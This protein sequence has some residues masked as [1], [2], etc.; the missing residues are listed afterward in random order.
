MATDWFCLEH[1]G[2]LHGPHTIYDLR[3]LHREGT[4]RDHTL[5]RHE[6]IGTKTLISVLKGTSGVS[7]M[8]VNVCIAKPP[9]SS[10]A[11]STPPL[12]SLS[13]LSAH[14]AIG[15]TEMKRG[16]HP[17]A[18]HKKQTTR[19]NE[20]THTQKMDGSSPKQRLVNTNAPS[21]KQ[22]ASRGLDNGVQSYGRGHGHVS[23]LVTNQQQ[24]SLNPA[25]TAGHKPS[26]SLNPND[27]VITQSRPM[28]ARASVC[29]K[30]ESLLPPREEPKASKSLQRTDL[31]TSRKLTS[32]EPLLISDDEE[33]AF[34][35]LQHAQN[36]NLL[37]KEE[38]GTK[39]ARP[40]GSSK[41]VHLRANKETSGR[42]VVQGIMKGATSII[43]R[44]NTSV[45]SSTKIG[46]AN[47]ARR[48][49]DMA[50]DLT[51]QHH[52]GPVSVAGAL[53]GSAGQVPEGTMTN[54]AR[55]RRLS[56]GNLEAQPTAMLER[57]SNPSLTCIAHESASRDERVTSTA[58]LRGP[59]KGVEAHCSTAGRPSLPSGYAYSSFNPASAS[60]TNPATSK[61]SAS[62][63]ISA[64]RGASN[65]WV[66]DL[67]ESGFSG[68]EKQMTKKS[69]K[70]MNLFESVQQ[71]PERMRLNYE[72]VLIKDIDVKFREVGG[73]EVEFQDLC[74]LEIQDLVDRGSIPTSA[75]IYYTGDQELPSVRVN[76]LLESHSAVL[77]LARSVL[78]KSWQQA[79]DSPPH[80]HNY[81][82]SP[83][84]GPMEDHPGYNYDDDDTRQPDL[85]SPLLPSSHQTISNQHG[86]AARQAPPHVQPFSQASSLRSHSS[87]HAHS[88][89]R[90][91][92]AEEIGL[93]KIKTMIGRSGTLMRA[94]GPPSSSWPKPQ[95]ETSLASTSAVHRLQHSVL[96]PPISQQQHGMLM[97]S[98]SLQQQTV[99][100]PLLMTAVGIHQAFPPMSFEISQDLDLLHQKLLVEKPQLGQQQQQQTQNNSAINQAEVSLPPHLQYPAHNLPAQQFQ[101]GSSALQTAP[102]DGS[103]YLQDTA[104]SMLLGFMQQNTWSSSAWSSVLGD[105]G[106]TAGGTV[107]GD[108]SN[109]VSGAGAA[110]LVP[111]PPPHLH[112]HL[113]GGMGVGGSGLAHATSKF[114]V[115]ED[116]QKL[117]DELQKDEEAMH[118]FVF[119]VKPATDFLS[120]TY[121]PSA[122]VDEANE[123]LM[124]E[125]GQQI[126]EASDISADLFADYNDADL[127]GEE[128]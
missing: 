110:S 98:S 76:V 62:K 72:D 7:A 128:D 11:Q 26:T 19:D 16:I 55:A 53:E 14:E 68:R 115:E 39:S 69:L 90:I 63:Q 89:N 96:P 27:Y 108:G 15:I 75:M 58:G 111:A 122:M 109:L 61:Y 21:T 83:S 94:S 51:M 93:S 17:S 80:T 42:S 10:F 101:H 84:N 113:P 44:S 34:K 71:L 114:H 1:D 121:L 33:E 31:N 47:S 118:T 81:V 8:T 25:L 77:Q 102:S 123:C 97:S 82:S 85:P 74:V 67:H 104:L 92:T 66:A 119:K 88:E 3:S 57:K 49:S 103:H 106:S 64:S 79:P 50:Q 45:Q 107:H 100:P 2:A 127:Y 56:T 12:P 32:V 9:L 117:E 116:I 126:V 73:K 28:S 112:D 87:A 36:H 91:L 125:G 65:F 43:D 41:V 95:Q 29:H 48:A 38:I 78:S 6:W 54:G 120:Q 30:K 24:E 35:K 86:V 70:P 99:V 20:T 37:R 5:V 124:K 105:V 13:R 46:R 23:G 40:V 52:G 18:L 60:T 59:A 4:L 22:S